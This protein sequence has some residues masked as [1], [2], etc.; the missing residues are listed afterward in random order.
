MNEIPKSVTDLNDKIPAIET[1][2]SRKQAYLTFGIVGLA[3]LMAS[4]DST[5][6]A[7]GLP[8]MLT[9]L[10]SNLALIGWTM[11]GFQFSQSIVMP[12]VGKLSDELGRKRIFLLAVL[13][14][15]ASSVACGVAPNVFLLIIFR[16]IQGIGGGAFLPSATG[17][18]ADTFSERRGT[19]IGLFGS[20][21][22]I[23]GIIGPN[24]GGLIID[25]LSWRWIF[26]VNLPIG[27]LLLVLGYRIL[28]E[29]KSPRKLN[30]QKIDAVGV[31]IFVAAIM[32]LLFALTI[33][34][35]NPRDTGPIT[36]ILIVTG[37]VLFIVFMRYEDGVKQ[38][39][40]DT[41]LLRW[42]PFFWVNVY[43]FVFGAVVFGLVSFI[44]YYATMSY[45]MTA[46]Q[47]G[48]LLTPRSLT[49]I[50]ASAFTSFFI[51]RLRYRAPMIIGLLIIAGSLLLLGQGY[52]DVTVLGIDFH[53]L[54]LLTSFVAI[55]GIGMGIANPAANN[56]A[57]D[58]IPEKVAA[59][60]GIR[61][62][63][64]SIGGL[65]GITSVTLILS[66]FKDQTTG[67]QDIYTGSAALLVLL[68]PVVFF[69]P[70]AASNRR[71]LKK[72]VQA[73]L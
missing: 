69:I 14:F 1:R 7:V 18:I 60:A 40:L 20:I 44:P 46:G 4:I 64:R 22:P 48:L 11:T 21:F 24:I 31:M 71:R 6:V 2:A 30:G 53:D 16:V 61:G 63:M 23:G 41:K 3:L 38:P 65:F 45:G 28:S 54:V 19:A 36:W 42:W 9:D 59:V 68:I 47:D 34:A 49:M 26:F 55:S 32:S 13:L 50:I 51:I 12:I 17:I 5:I 73:G 58:L 67:M 10:R 33:W 35:D 56:A 70:D 27:I 39:M 52:H 62:M 72:S 25:N 43:N 66:Y 29:S 15:T 8:T 37:I 57:L